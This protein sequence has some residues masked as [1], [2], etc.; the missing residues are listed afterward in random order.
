MVI[1][2]NFL[3]SLKSFKN[4]EKGLR[5]QMI[6][7][8]LLPKSSKK[9]R[10][11][12]LIWLLKSYLL[13]RISI[14]SKQNKFKLKESKSNTT[15]TKTKIKNSKHK[16]KQLKS[17]LKNPKSN[18]KMLLQLQARQKSNLHYYKSNQQLR[19]QRMETLQKQEVFS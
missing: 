17:W 5:F 4:S 12:K 19:V 9:W 10:S 15:S 13:K 14:N 6:S 7:Q 2:K 8:Q 16:L 18:F 11:Q 1:K 3:I